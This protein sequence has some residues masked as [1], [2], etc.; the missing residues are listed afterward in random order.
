MADSTQKI[1]ASLTVPADRDILVC[2]FQRGA[3]DGLNALVPYGD[4]AYK[5]H[6]STIYVP[7]PGAPDNPTFG[8]T[9]AIDIDGFFGL[10]PALDPLKFI[11]DAGDLAL[12]HACGVPHDS[13]SHFTA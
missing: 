3:A 6:R 4:A 13:R 9:P 12:V 11:Y 2:I 1:A 7:A 10:H 8:T 5:T